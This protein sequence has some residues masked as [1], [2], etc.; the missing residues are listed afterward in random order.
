[1]LLCFLDESG[2]HILS[3]GDPN[4]P[5]FVLAGVV[6]EEGYYASV[7]QPEMEELKQR[8]FGKRDLVLHTADI[9]RNRNGFEGLKDPGF[10]ARFYQEIN[11]AMRRWDY[12]VLGVLVDKRGLVEV[13]G[14][15]AWD[16]YDLSL[17]FL[18]ERL[19]FLSE[20]RGDRAKIIAESRSSSLD[21]RLE[22]TWEGLLEKGTHYVRAQRLR[23][24]VEGLIFKKKGDNE[25]G[26]Q[27]ADLVASPIGRYYLGKPA[28]EDWEIVAGKLRYG[29][30]AFPKS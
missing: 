16:P 1:M 19:V 27:L 25:A 26:L 23:R 2:D 17:G 22:R 6:V 21:Q 8:L 12:T 15:S 4:Y 28:K 7:I 10:R 11:A 18:V 14:S 13:Y 29:L 20:E 3:G 9:T 24:R 5:V 30:V